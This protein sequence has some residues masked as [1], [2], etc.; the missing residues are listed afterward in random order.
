M[1]DFI[2]K[3]IKLII[4]KGYGCTLSNI[5]QFGLLISSTMTY[6]W[7]C[8]QSNMAGVACGAGTA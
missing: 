2:Y 6:H 3:I 1:S 8:N 5:T 4:K 7:C